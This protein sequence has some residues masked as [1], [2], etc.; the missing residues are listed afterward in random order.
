M[1]KQVTFRAVVPESCLKKDS[2]IRM[3]FILDRTLE[4]I[5]VH[6]E[7]SQDDALTKADEK[8]IKST[9]KYIN[10]TAKAR[11]PILSM[12]RADAKSGDRLNYINFIY[13]Y[14][15]FAVF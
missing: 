5:E 13:Y 14:V 11:L 10:I 3:K 2:H 12:S 6:C 4:P 8:N 9:K 1:H 15:I 7:I